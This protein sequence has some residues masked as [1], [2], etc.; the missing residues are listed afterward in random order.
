MV[1]VTPVVE[2]LSARPASCRRIRGAGGLLATEDVRANA[3]ALRLL[4]P[5]MRRTVTKRERETPGNAW[6]SIG[7]LGGGYVVRVTNETGKGGKGRN[8]KGGGKCEK[9]GDGKV[10]VAPGCCCDLGVIREWRETVQTLADG[11]Q[12]SVW[13]GH[14]GPTGDNVTFRRAGDR[15][16]LFS[17]DAPPD[18]NAVPVAE[19]PTHEWLTL[20]DGA[21]AEARAFANALHHEVLSG[22]KL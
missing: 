6:D 13:N 2:W 17:G 22:E 8:V 14:D 15:L 7:R 9:N 4:A 1:T 19:L 11:A 3:D 10:V 12:V 20:L 21:E 5:E 18:A 16:A